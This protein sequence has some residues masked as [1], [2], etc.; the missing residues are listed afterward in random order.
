MR[1]AAG[2]LMIVHSVSTIAFMVGFLIHFFWGPATE[3]SPLVMGLAA[4]I[5]GVFII[6]G[7]VFCLKRKSWGICFASSIVLLVFMI[8]NLLTFVPFN[9]FWPD[10]PLWVVY[11]VV[12]PL[13]LPLG[14]L[15]QTFVCLRRSEWQKNSSPTG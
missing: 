5:A 6:R 15:P 14:I 10:L 8:L 2:I 9:P 13:S 4:I 11:F 1:K 12:V 7:G 3:G